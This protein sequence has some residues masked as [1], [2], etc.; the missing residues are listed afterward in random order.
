VTARVA[1][2]REPETRDDGAPPR[3]RLQKPSL[4]VLVPLLAYVVLVLL[5]ITTSSIGIAGMREDPAHPLGWQLG[6]ALKVRSDEYSTESPIWLGQMAIGPGDAVTPLAVSPDFFAQLPDGPVSSVVF[7]DGTL[8]QLGPWLPDGM[9]FAAKWWLPTLLLAIGMPVWFRQVTGSLAWGYLGSALVVVAPANAWW[10]GRPVNTLGFMFAAC[11]LINCA[12]HRWSSRPRLPFVLTTLL[13]GVLLARFPTYYQPLAI[14]IGSP[15][16]LATVGYLLVELRTWRRRLLV[17]GSA[18]LSAVLFTGALVLENLPAIKAGLTTVY[19]GARTSTSESLSIGRVFGATNFGW[20]ESL[21]Q[22]GQ[23]LG[24]VPTE[25]VSSFTVLTLI[26]GLLVVHRP[27]RGGRATAA[28]FWPLWISAV[29]WLSWCTVSYGSLGG[30]IPVINLVPGW[31]A[32]Q[33]AGFVAT[34]V[35]C[36]FMTQWRTERPW[37][38][39]VAAGSATALLSAWAGSSL[40]EDFLPDLTT[41]M[42]WLSALVAGTV[43]FAVVRWPQRPAALGAMG[44]A[45]SLLTFAVNPVLGGLADLRDSATARYFLDQGRVARGQQQVWATDDALL[46]AL[47][48]ATGTPTLSTRQQIGPDVAG[49]LR[50]DPGGRHADVWNRG[51]THI[52]FTWTDATDLTFTN[53]SPDVAMM[54][55]SPCVVA[56]RM[57]ELRYIVSEKPLTA[58]CLTRVQD[59]T[60]S[61]VDRTV[62]AVR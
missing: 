59:I 2:A 38:V 61:G 13:A 27:W 58:S 11:A 9:L 39:P 8:L 41:V 30:N 47:L 7:L 29:F 36:V 26:T 37:R 53:P 46:D 33:G 4:V 51:G 43:V 54:T 16:L 10:S 50:L 49:W 52:E 23:G 34:C 17:L 5:S 32:Q 35:F 6:E 28:A 24:A 56:Q 19:P 14:M 3:R 18:G 22:S 25:L 55:G 44:L 21:S 12:A 62:Y 42:V 20:V 15:V 31:R 60:W 40:Q 48:T 57:T 1:G 45:A